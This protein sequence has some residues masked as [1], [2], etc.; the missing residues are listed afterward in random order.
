M[1]VSRRKFMEEKVGYQSDRSL[2]NR[3]KKAISEDFGDSKSYVHWMETIRNPRGPPLGI[4]EEVI[5]KSNFGLLTGLEEIKK[6]L[7]Y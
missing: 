3:V 2:T 1:R 6:L 5:T 4:R 7:T